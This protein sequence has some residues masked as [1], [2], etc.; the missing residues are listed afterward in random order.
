MTTEPL[1]SVSIQATHR[2]KNNAANATSI[3]P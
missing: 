3:K 1:C 2:E